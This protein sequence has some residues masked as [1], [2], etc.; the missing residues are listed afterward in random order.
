MKPRTGKGKGPATD[1]AEMR[2]RSRQRAREFA[3][4]LLSDSKIHVGGSTPS[5]SVTQGGGT[6]DTEEEDT[7][8]SFGTRPERPPNSSTIKKELMGHHTEESPMMLSVASRGLP[9]PVPSMPDFA[10]SV[11]SKQSSLPSTG[12]AG[13][14]AVEPSPF[15]TIRRRR[16]SFLQ[17]AYTTPSTSRSYNRLDKGGDGESAL[18]ESLRGSR[19]FSLSSAAGSKPTTVRSGDRVSRRSLLDRETVATDG[20]GRR[21]YGMT[22]RQSTPRK[23]FLDVAK[24]DSDGNNPPHR[25]NALD[26]ENREME[27]A[28]ANP[29]PTTA[30]SNASQNK[31]MTKFSIRDKSRGNI[32]EKGDSVPNPISRNQGR[33]KL[34]SYYAW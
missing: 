17:H 34:F 20:K 7:D 31:E 16:T 29:L 3:Q 1:K 12:D 13:Q 4:T 27:A 22:S 23:S 11:D 25:E 9:P 24:I 33:V 26:V 6:E 32:Q 2:Q 28:G 18:P 5:D 10:G 15:Q 14:D 30:T 21:G 19:D 8:E